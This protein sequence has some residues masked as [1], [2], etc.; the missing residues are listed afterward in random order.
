[1]YNLTNFHKLNIPMEPAP[2]QELEF[3][4]FIFKEYSLYEIK[5]SDET[6]IVQ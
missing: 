1:M 6:E 3:S 5:N 4:G 2:D